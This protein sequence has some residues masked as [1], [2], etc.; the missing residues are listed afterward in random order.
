MKKTL[1]L[2]AAL[3]LCLSGCGSSDSSDA[4]ATPVPTPKPTVEVTASPAP[5]ASPMEIA[6]SYID[7]EVDE[8]IAVIGEPLESDYASSC[9]GPGKDGNLVYD[10]F[11]VYTYKEGSSEIVRVVLAS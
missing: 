3:L 1:V 7:C 10:G 2:T 9:L 4:A 8:L 6:Q 11:T 5:T